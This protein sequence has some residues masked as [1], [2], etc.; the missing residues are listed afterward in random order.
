M[1]LPSLRQAVSEITT[2]N[3]DYAGTYKGIIIVDDTLYALRAANDDGSGINRLREQRLAKLTVSGLLSVTW[4]DDA[5]DLGVFLT[6][7]AANTH[8]RLEDLTWHRGTLYGIGIDGLYS[9]DADTGAS[10]FLGTVADS[11]GQVLTLSNPTIASDGGQIHLHVTASNF[12]DTLYWGMINPD[13]RIYTPYTIGQIPSVG[14]Q[15]GN[16]FFYALSRA[17]SF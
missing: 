2:I 16:G 6:S 17:Y 1:A 5:V 8:R 12:G 11:N 7:D 9:I 15:S 10:T 13:T 14:S 4:E 3:Y